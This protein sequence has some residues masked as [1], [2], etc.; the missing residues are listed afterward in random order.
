MA[1][2]KQSIRKHMTVL[3]NGDVISKEELI[4]IS[5]SWDEKQETFFRKMLKQGGHFKLAGIRYE[6]TLKRDDRT[7]SD[8]TKDS[9]VIQIP[10][11][12][13]KF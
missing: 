12:D 3:V 13:G 9:G 11:E 5:E 6:V 4:L 7:R 8:G 2:K 10:G 1:L